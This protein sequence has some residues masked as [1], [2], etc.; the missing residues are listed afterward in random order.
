LST[1]A[2]GPV[3]LLLGSLVLLLAGAG[4]HWWLAERAGS[5]HDV[6]ILRD[7]PVVIEPWPD[8]LRAEGSAWRWDHTV[9][10]MQLLIAKANN[11]DEEFVVMDPITVPDAKTLAVDFRVGNVRTVS[12]ALVLSMDD[13][14]VKIAVNE[15]ELARKG[16]VW[17]HSG[18]LQNGQRKPFEIARLELRD[19]QDHVIVRYQNPDMGRR[20]RFRL[21][22][23]GGA[24]KA[25]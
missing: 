23:I 18:F 6:L 10:G 4:G 9:S 14:G 17:A 11:P 20:V 3:R 22:M 7:G 1:H 16:E 19:A 12:N 8:G 5:G 13:S 2:I 15:G 21:R 24:P 25:H